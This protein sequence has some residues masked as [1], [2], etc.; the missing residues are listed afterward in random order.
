M[1]NARRL[2]AGITRAS[3]RFSAS[4]RTEKMRHNSP[5]FFFFL[6]GE[7][8][9]AGTRWNRCGKWNTNYRCQYHVMGRQGE[10][11]IANL[12]HSQVALLWL[13]HGA[14]LIR[15]Q[16]F[17]AGSGFSE[18][19]R[20]R[21]MWI[22]AQCSSTVL[23]RWLHLFWQALDCVWWWET[24][25]GWRSAPALQLTM[26]IMETRRSWS[27]HQQTP[28]RLLILPS[29]GS[30]AETPKVARRGAARAHTHARQSPAA[31]LANLIALEQQNP[32]AVLMTGNKFRNE[33]DLIWCSH[34]QKGST[35]VIS[36]CLLARVRKNTR[37][38]IRNLVTVKCWGPHLA[39][40]HKLDKLDAPPSRRSK[41]Q[42]SLYFSE[43][44][45]LEIQHVVLSCCLCSLCGL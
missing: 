40:T 31:T 17:A 15:R 13:W 21:R 14:A 4:Q 28:A 41:V 45:R 11:I 35:L 18:A 38:N 27:M 8:S 34:S 32:L 30:T 23:S 43:L 37:K 9:C 39:R 1:K 20:G 25:Q 5:F 29:K 36:F 22:T 16:R 44:V 7:N 6:Q 2:L 10:S 3:A 42:S 33:N 24:A 26:W 19:C 12:L